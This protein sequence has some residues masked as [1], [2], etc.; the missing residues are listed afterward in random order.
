MDTLHVHIRAMTDDDRGMVFILAEEQLRP[1]AAAAGHPERF[2]DREF[3]ELIGRGEVFVAESPRE[4]AVIA[5]YVVLETEAEADALTVRCVCVGPAFEGQ[6]VG[7]RLLDWAEG[8]AYSRGLARLTAPLPGEDERS[9]RL[10]REHDF[11]PAPAADDRPELIVME[12][13][14]R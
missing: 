5:G 10:Y 4:P 3:L 1:L 2:N 7:H 13:R 12:K 8:L 14:L 9:R 6:R 11:V